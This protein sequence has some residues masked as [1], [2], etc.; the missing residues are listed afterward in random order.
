MEKK[1]WVSP[2][3]EVYGTVEEITQDKV[4]TKTWGPGDDFW[5]QITT[6]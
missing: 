3:L 4:K 2:E 6:V 1:E 5:E